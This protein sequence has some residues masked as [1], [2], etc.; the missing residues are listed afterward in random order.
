MFNHLLMHL[1]IIYVQCTHSSCEHTQNINTY[2]IYI[3]LSTSAPVLF[4]LLTAP[5]QCFCCHLSHLQLFNLSLAG[6]TC[7]FNK[8]QRM[9]CPVV[10]WGTMW[11]LSY[12][13]ISSSAQL[14]PAFS[15]AWTWEY[16]PVLKIPPTVYLPCNPFLPMFVSSVCVSPC[17]RSLR[18]LRARRL[19]PALGSLSECWAN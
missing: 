18:P 2:I 15:C 4:P 11:S 1:I 13:A 14:P 10:F 6:C 9:L 16:H 17:L 3:L 8:G 12:T 7:A 19:L 5:F